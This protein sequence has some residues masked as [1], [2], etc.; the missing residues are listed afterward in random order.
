MT[1][2]VNIRSQLIRGIFV[3]ISLIIECD[4]QTNCCSGKVLDYEDF[5]SIYQ[6]D[7][8][9]WNSI[10]TTQLLVIIIISYC[11]YYYYYYSLLISRSKQNSLITI[12]IFRS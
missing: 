5:H 9:N 2:A 10:S 12:N 8:N 4:G 6:T 11:Y 7:I 1:S 3:F